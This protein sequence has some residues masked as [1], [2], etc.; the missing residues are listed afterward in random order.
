MFVDIATP[1]IRRCFQNRYYVNYENRGSISNDDVSIDVT[2]DSRF[3][4]TDAT[5]PYTQINATTY[6]FYIGTVG[7]FE[8]GDFSFL[9]MMEC[10][11][12]T[13]GETI[14]AE[15]RIYPDTICQLPDPNWTGASLSVSGECE[16][17]SVRFV[18]TN[19][20]TGAMIASLQY[21]VIEDVA[22]MKVSDPFTLGVGDEIQEVIKADGQTFHFQVDQVTGH[23]GN[24]RPSITIENCGTNATLGIFNQFGQNDLN[25]F[26]DIECR[27]VI[28]SFDPNDKAAVPRGIDVEHK[29]QPNSTIEYTI[30]FQNTGTDTAFLVQ[31]FDTISPL[32]NLSTFRAG[33]SSHDYSYE[34]FENG[35]VK[36]RFEN[37]MLPDSNVNQLESNGFVKYKIAMQKDAPLGSTIYNAADIFFDYNDPIYTNQTFHLIDEPWI[38]VKTE[39]TFIPDV[40]IKVF[41]NPFTTQATFELKNAPF[42]KKQFQLFSLSGNEIHAQ[43]FDNQQFVFQRNHLPKGIYVYEI[44]KGTMKIAV[45]KLVVQ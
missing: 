44:K 7:V 3:Q 32:L 5:V 13:L 37:I 4:I 26:V 19:D 8:K 16:G 14:C 41:P 25:P 38:S 31:I 33:A 9:T 43:Q 27:E 12:V 34:I 29:I 11:S 6:N 20:G 40:E 1:R 18:I 42:G 35:I 21:L 28:G 39:E 24:S 45:G 17:D 36:F 22:L 2:L 15:A 10:D 30:R 23:P